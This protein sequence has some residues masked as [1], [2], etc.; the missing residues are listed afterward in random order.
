MDNRARTSVC[1][2]NSST[3]EKMRVRRATY[4]EASVR[5]ASQFRVCMAPA[6][7]VPF[8]CRANSERKLLSE[9][10]SLPGVQDILSSGGV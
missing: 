7:K 5:R 8:V 4:A 3:S 2:G 1:M 9:D 10:T 6:N